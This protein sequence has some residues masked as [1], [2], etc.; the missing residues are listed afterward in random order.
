MFLRQRH[1][2]PEIMDQPDLDS[3]RHQHALRGLARINALSNSAG[4]LWP[5]LAALASAVPRPLRLLDLATGGGD[6]LLRLWRRAQRSGVALKIDGCDLSPVAIEHA[7]ATAAAAG[8]DVHF[9]VHDALA[10]PPGGEYDV[11]VC[12]LFLHHLD[13]DDAVTLLRHLR[14]AAPVVVINDLERG[15]FGWLLAWLGTRLLSTSRVVHVDGPRSVAGAFT[16]TEARG[17]A[18][19]AGLIDVQVTRHW[20]CRFRLVGRRP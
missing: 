2:L 5:P 10:G 18:E 6:V 20:P 19:R 15:L 3:A 4:I 16:T 14:A 11:A 17:L 1:R 9:F 13:E 7:Q 12:S 8:A